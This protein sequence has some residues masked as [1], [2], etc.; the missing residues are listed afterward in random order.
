MLYVYIVY[1]MT[2]LIEH[3]IEELRKLLGNRGVEDP[4]SR[5]PRDKAYLLPRKS[6]APD[7]RMKFYPTGPILDQGSFPHCVAFSTVQLLRTGPISNVYNIPPVDLYNRCQLVD[8]WAGEDYDGTSV[9]AAM[10]IL[11]EDGY[12]SEY[13]WAFDIG[14]VINYVLSTGPMIVGT[15]WYSDMFDVVN[16]FIRATGFAVGGHAYLIKGINLD[17]PCLDGTKGA[18]RIINSWGNTWGNGPHGGLA[19]ISIRDMER[20]ILEDGEAACIKEI[21]R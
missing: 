9:R 2:Q 4:S 19:W 14:T 10:K 18:F 13:N 11:K 21:K 5:D 12:I 16:G 8:E 6:V 17:Y 15:Y 20:L 3:N 7:L 1:T